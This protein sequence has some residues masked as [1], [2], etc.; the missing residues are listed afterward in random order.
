MNRLSIVSIGAVLLVTSMLADAQ[1][2]CD[3]K[4]NPTA[5]FVDSA[6]TS[7]DHC[8]TGSLPRN[9]S[10]ACIG[11]GEA[12]I[13][14]LYER[15]IYASEHNSHTA[16]LKDFHASWRAAMDGV[17]PNGNEPPA[18]YKARQAADRNALEA[19]A[20]RLKID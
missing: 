19:K 17:R 13:E 8:Q 10:F 5:C 11:E 18:A 6:L 1:Q 15:A 2:P 12:L 7:F 14:P 4:T 3:A 9:D 20:E 16:L